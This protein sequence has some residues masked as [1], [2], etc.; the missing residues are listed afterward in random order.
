MPGDAIGIDELRAALE[1]ASVTFGV[2]DIALERLGLQVRD[3]AFAC[4][5]VPIATGR[6]MQRES[7]GACEL[8]VAV[9]LQPGHRLDDGSFDYR[10]R[11]L[12]RPVRRG[13]VLA[14]CQPPVP[15]VDGRTV[16]DRAI[17][18]EKIPSAA[19]LSFGDGL[20]RDREGSVV[21]ARDGVVR[22]TDGRIE[23]G[24]H[25]VH[26]GDVDLRCGHL[27]MHGS[28]TITGD[29]T[30]KFEVQAT[31]GVQIEKS[32]ARGTVY[33]GRDIAVKGGLIG[34][35]GASVLAEGDISAEHAQGASIACGGALHLRRA[36]INCEIQAARVQIDGPVRGGCLQAEYEIVVAEAGARLGGETKLLVA[37]AGDRPLRA[38]FDEERHEKH[39][40]DRMAASLV[41][42]RVPPRR[43]PGAEAEDAL[44]TSA[45][46]DVV[47]TVHAGTTIGIGPHRLVVDE[48]RRHVRFSWDPEH[49]VIRCDALS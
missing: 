8:T 16:T 14:R 20:E 17:P 48:T 32:V 36:A 43:R 1:R 15:G 33:S 19:S 26:E 30:A 27:D 10:D 49:H 29:V 28:L 44:V 38:R 24:D 11:G 41:H 9:G 7:T 34:S 22:R 4:G 23:I 46:V 25:Y 18:F 13:E 2:D 21:A 40:A 37:V 6:A 39:V 42:S 3:G 47:G 45:R 5:P 31:G 35:V 12:L